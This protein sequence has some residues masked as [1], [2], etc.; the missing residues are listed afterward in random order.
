MTHKRPF[1]TRR[2]LLKVL[3]A[4]PLLV[5]TAAAA[6]ETLFDAAWPNT[7]FSRLAIDLGEVISGGPP[8]DG[9]P[10]ILD[11]SFIGASE[12]TWLD[13][14]EPVMTYVPDDGPARAYPIRYLMWH[15]IVNDVVDGE[16]ITVTFCPLCNTGMVFEGRLGGRTLTFGVSGLLR[17]S[18]MIMYTR[19]R[20]TSGRQGL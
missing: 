10:A 6:Q 9:I 20:P 2:Y 11:P 15:E 18:D 4:L 1:E 7:D 12:E 3:A 19:P 17:H 14:R 16:P 13:D 8:R 5:V